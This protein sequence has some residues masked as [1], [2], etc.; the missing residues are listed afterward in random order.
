ARE[1][2]PYSGPIRPGSRM[3]PAIADR[4]RKAAQR[5]PLLLPLVVLTAAATV[6]FAYVAHVLW[7]RWPGPAVS[8]D[9]PALPIT[10]GGVTFNIPPAAIRVP[11][12]RRPGTQERV[13]LVFAWPS[14]EAPDP[15]IRPAA[16]AA[17]GTHAL[18]RIFVTITAAAG[19][20]DPSERVLTVYSH[21]TA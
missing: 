3:P 11:M 20:L 6:A 4:R 9:T 10:I 15:A 19:A 12:Q 21:Y 14:L 13:D 1:A 16:G 18:D 8:V 17:L 7:P 5:G 2:V